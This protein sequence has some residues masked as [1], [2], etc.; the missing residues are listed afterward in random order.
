MLTDAQVAVLCDIGQ[1]M[2]FSDD[3]HEELV[4]LITDGYVDK[5]GDTFQGRSCRGRARRRTERSL[6]SLKSK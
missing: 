3:E 2:A 6:I 4:R 5:D 1:S